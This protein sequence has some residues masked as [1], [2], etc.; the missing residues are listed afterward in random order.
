MKPVMLALVLLMSSFLCHAQTD[1][2]VKKDSL[3]SKVIPFNFF[4]Y[5]APHI[6]SGNYYYY[7]Y[8]QKTQ[9]TRYTFYNYS[10]Y[11]GVVVYDKHAHQNL[12]YDTYRP[13]GFYDPKR[14]NGFYYPNHT[15]GFL[16]Q[17]HPS[18]FTLVEGILWQIFSKGK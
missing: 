17:Y 6:Y 5:K 18:D 15:F 3:K 7:S 16:N 13:H 12:V 10:F 11:N 1:T 9:L 2:I 8:Y 4:S 14:P